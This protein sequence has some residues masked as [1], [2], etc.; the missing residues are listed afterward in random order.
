MAVTKGEEKMKKALFPLIAVVLV[1][2]LA[3]MA[4]LATF[5]FP[6]GPALAAEN[7][8]YV[9]LESLGPGKWINTNIGWIWAK[10]FHLRV[11]GELHDGWCIEPEVEIGEGWCFNATLLDKPRETPWCEIGYIMANYSPDSDD[12]AAAI[13]LA[14]W[15]YMGGGKDTIVA[16]DPTA[17]ETRAREIYDDAAGKCLTSGRWVVV[18]D[19]TDLGPAEQQI[20]KTIILTDPS[21]GGDVEPVNRVSVL[22]PWVGLAFLLIGGMTWFALRRRST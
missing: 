15:K 14:I 9:C 19:P 22:A 11:D 6:A 1:L 18:I 13:Q 4:S 16:T 3:L 8:P 2:G 12:E 10:L 17:V 7:D 20:Q 5:V 21:V